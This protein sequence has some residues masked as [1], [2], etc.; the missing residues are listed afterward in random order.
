MIPVELVSR[1]VNFANQP[2][3]AIAV[4]DIRARKKAEADLR[5]LAQHDSLT[6]LPNR[7]SFNSKLDREIAAAAANGKHL[8]LLCMDLDRFKEVNDLFGH[9]AGDALLQT[10]ARSA[11]GILGEG[12]MLARLG[13]DEFAVIAP[14]LPDPAAAGR[15]AESILEAFRVENED[16][17]NGGLASGSIGIAIYPND[18]TERESLMSHADA[19]LYRAKVEGRGTYRFFEAA[20]GAEVKERR[21]IEYDLLH[22]ISQRPVAPRLSA[23]GAADDTGRDRI[24]SAA[25]LAAPDRAAPSRP[26]SSSRSPRRAD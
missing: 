24:R 16:V 6:G 2:R 7:R 15:I 14:G 11:G 10:V 19:A 22:A 3:Q 9:A 20:M 8:A 5:H 17:S 18:A 26:Q 12:Q 23:A 13:G 21:Q 4:R 1:P 25:A